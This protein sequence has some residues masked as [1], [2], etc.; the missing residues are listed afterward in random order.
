MT[1]FINQKEKNV[2]IRHNSILTLMKF[3][4]ID[5][6]HLIFLDVK[7]FPIFCLR[8]YYEEL[9]VKTTL[10]TMGHFFAMK[11]NYCP[12]DIICNSIA[13]KMPVFEKLKTRDLDLLRVK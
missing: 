5:M 13:L 6:M 2:S 4:R 10:T 11:L 7:Y 8:N 9:A 1:Y 3:F 12:S